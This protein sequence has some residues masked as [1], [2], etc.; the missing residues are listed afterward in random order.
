[1]N[2][3]ARGAYVRRVFLLTDQEL[4]QKYMQA[5]ASAQLSGAAGLDSACRSNFAVRYVLLTEAE[6][7]QYVASGKHF[8]LLVKEGCAISMSP[9]Y[10]AD[11][12]LVTLRFRSGPRHVD[13]LREIFDHLWGVGRPLADL[14]LPTSS[15]DIDLVTNELEGTSRSA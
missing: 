14:K 15:I 13:G 9:V 2:A 5:I 3:A 8:G 7:R 4:S 11:E 1:R 6:R 12:K 10:D